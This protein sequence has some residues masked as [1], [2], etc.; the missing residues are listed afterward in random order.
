M[1]NFSE[2]YHFAPEKEI[3]VNVVDI[4]LFNRLWN[5]FYSR[6]YEYDPWTLGSGAIEIPEILLDSFGLTY[7]FPTD[8]AERNKNIQKLR[9]FLM[10]A[11]WYCI[12]DFIERYV[13]SFGDSSNGNELEKEVNLVLEQEKS[14]YRMVKGLITPITNP[15]ELEIIRKAMSTKFVSVNTHF[16]K[17][18][19]LYSNRKNPDYENSIK[20]SISAVEAICCIIN[21]KDATLN[22]AIDK[23]KNNGIHIHPAM[24]KAFIALYGYTSDESGIRHGG[25]DFANAPAEDAKYMLVSCSAFVNYLIEKWSKI[26]K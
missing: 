17:A 1:I 5:L 2:R 7:D 8:Y 15:T 4:G 20:E 14:G 24:E 25:I 11:E 10:N 18:L 12:Y 6:E 26:Q 21:G 22:K 3:Q 9:K 19:K 16:E 13:E 23:L